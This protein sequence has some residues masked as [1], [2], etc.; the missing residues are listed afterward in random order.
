[1]QKKDYFRFFISIILAVI[2]IFAI[3]SPAYAMFTVVIVLG[4][5]FIVWGAVMIIR[6]LNTPSHNAS[7]FDGG[8]NKK[9]SRLHPVLYAI[10]YGLLIVAG[11]LL[12]VFSVP[13]KDAFMPVI[14]GL[15]ALA[16]GVFATIN[17]VDFRRKNQDVLLPV[18]AL[19]VSFATAIALFIL[20]SSSVGF[21]SPAGGVFLLIFG[22]V[23][24]IEIATSSRKKNTQRA[25][26]VE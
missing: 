9:K 2:G 20:S 5:V 13:A 6:R 25:T 12:L 24:A 15:W 14:I 8:E 1:M 18:I 23:T 16:A 7:L 21:N 17:A 10:L 4:I 19:I 3:F 11:I 22:F 26:K